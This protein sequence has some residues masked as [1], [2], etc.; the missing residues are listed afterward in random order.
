M[1]DQDQERPK[2]RDKTVGVR[3]DPE[4]YDKAAARAK[5]EGR[6]ISAILR[7]FFFLWAEDE[8]PSPPV[9]EDERRRAAQRR[10]KKKS[11]E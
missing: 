2:P 5:K 11:P 10:K 9:I 3:V 7:A 6:S 8:I 4:T 1:A